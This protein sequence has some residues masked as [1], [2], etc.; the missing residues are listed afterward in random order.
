MPHVRVAIISEIYLQCT[1]SKSSIWWIYLSYEDYNKIKKFWK[2]FL[3]INL[4]PIFCKIYPV[5]GLL[6]HNAVNQLPE[7]QIFI[8]CAVKIN[9]FGVGKKQFRK[10]SWNIFEN[11]ALE[12]FYLTCTGSPLK[13]TWSFGRDR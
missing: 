9:T 6:N 10:I 12:V 2:Y 3:E 7:I 8:F 13:I 5:C 1:Q 11:S 4:R